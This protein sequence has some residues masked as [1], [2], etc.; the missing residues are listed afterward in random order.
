MIPIIRIISRV[1]TCEI[2][3]RIRRLRINTI[4]D[5]KSGSTILVIDGLENVLAELVCNSANLW[6]AYRATS[7][8]SAKHFSI[9]LGLTLGF[10]FSLSKNLVPNT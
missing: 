1:D 5:S 10:L 3:R 2:I 7:G 4:K 8:T 9:C 6:V